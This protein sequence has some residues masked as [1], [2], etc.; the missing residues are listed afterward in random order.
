MRSET[1]DSVLR[2]T[3]GYVSWHHPTRVDEKGRFKVPAEFKREIDENYGAQFYIT[4]TDG[5]IAQLYPLKVWERKE[6]EDSGAASASTA[7]CGDFLDATSYY[8][9]VVEMDGQGRL[10]L[11]SLLR[12]EAGL[13]GDVS[14]V[15]KLDRLDVRNAEE[16]RKQVR[17]TRSLLSM[18]KRSRSWDLVTDGSQ[19][20]EDS[21]PGGRGWQNG[22]SGVWPCSQFF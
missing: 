16:Y 5:K 19:F 2:R 21:A 18:M 9:Q 14:V 7:P 10:L 1:G 22:S 17:K 15:G 3:G 6:K 8:G 20:D 12:E 11:P 13:K 4:S